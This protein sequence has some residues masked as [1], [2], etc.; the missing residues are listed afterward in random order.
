MNNLSNHRSVQQNALMGAG[1]AAILAS[2]LVLPQVTDFAFWALLAGCFLLRFW[3]RG[4]ALQWTDFGFICALAAWPAVTLSLELVH[5]PL[6]SAIDRPARLLLA[7]PLFLI[8]RSQALD[9]RWVSGGSL[10]GLSL[11]LLTY[12][13]NPFVTPDGLQRAQSFAGNPISYG[14]FML[15]LGFLGGLC[16][17]HAPRSRQVQWA[18][19]L[20]LIM[21]IAGAYFSG[22]RGVLV[23]VPALVV[24]FVL[25]TG[26]Q[27]ATLVLVL[28]AVGG[29]G[30]AW[31]MAPSITQRFLELLPILMGQDLGTVSLAEETSAGHRMRLWSVGL[32]L[33]ESS[34]WIGVGADQL[35]QTLQGLGAAGVLETGRVHLHN[36]WV[37]TLASYGAVG[38]AAL[39]ATLLGLF[40]L[41]GWTWSCMRGRAESLACSKDDARI[42]AGLGVLL[43]TAL[44]GFSMTDSLISNMNR[45]QVY[46]VLLAVCAGAARHA[47]MAQAIERSES[48]D[49]QA[50]HCQA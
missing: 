49:S 48:Q 35:R 16:W 30:L 4:P 20:C 10:V 18:S 44:V 15:V 3:S 34:P 19:A 17:L 5:G 31:F 28:G 13:L 46:T 25:L 36:E 45:V 38:A 47:A 39:L 24:G 12:S 9:L 32:G 1:V 22:T 21:G 14:Q 11:G 29:L 43:L 50:G 8:F 7:V 26:H 33:F 40:G 27:R 41:F 42:Q 23:T 2:A 37:H 6:L